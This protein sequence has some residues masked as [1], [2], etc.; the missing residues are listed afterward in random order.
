[1]K[2]LMEIFHLA[3]DLDLE[4]KGIKERSIIAEAAVERET[5]IE[6]E[7]GVELI[8]KVGQAI[9]EIEVRALAL[10]R[11]IGEGPD[12]AVGADLGRMVEN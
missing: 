1:M 3:T 8:V 2:A 12:L 9:R 10:A 6:A 11:D 7:A 4:K 5:R